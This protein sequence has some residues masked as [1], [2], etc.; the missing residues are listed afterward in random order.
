MIT[1]FVLPEV[2]SPR[3]EN[4]LAIILSGE[5]EMYLWIEQSDFEKIF[6]ACIFTDN[7][8]EILTLIGTLQDHNIKI[9]IYTN[10]ANKN[11]L[12]DNKKILITYCQ[13]NANLVLEQIIEVNSPLEEAM[14]L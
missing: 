9:H 7:L 6:E 14:Y 8:A 4:G 3:T 5:D 12:P 13:I 10:P 11:K 2:A 1:D